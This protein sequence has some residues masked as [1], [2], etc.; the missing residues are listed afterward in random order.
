V[1]QYKF[2]EEKDFLLH[3]AKKL[4]NPEVETIILA[5]EVKSSE[6][7]N[8]LSKF[9]W[10]MVD[11]IVID[12]DAGEVVA[13]QGDLEAWNEYVFGGGSWGQ[14]LHLTFLVMFIINLYSE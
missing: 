7:A 12:K 9:F 14:V 2:P 6:E 11:E 10:E 4:R 8:A 3:Y 1:I 5:G 13:G